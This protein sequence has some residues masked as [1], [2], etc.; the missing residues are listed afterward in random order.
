MQSALPVAIVLVGVIAAAVLR[1]RP[2][3]VK[4]PKSPPRRGRR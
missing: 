1:R 4:V 3:A 2:V